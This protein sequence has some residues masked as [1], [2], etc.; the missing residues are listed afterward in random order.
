MR[1]SYIQNNDLSVFD[2]YIKYLGALELDSEII[3]TEDA[4]D[5]VL[6]NAVFAKKCDPM[7]NA[8]AMDGIAV[9]AEATLNANDNHPVTLILNKDF[10]FVNTG[11]AIEG[12]FNAVI[13]IEEVL[14]LNDTTVQIVS[15]AY[16]W[17]H[18]RVKGESIVEGE[19]LLP[20]KSVLRPVDIGAVYASANITVEVI[21]K[22][23]VGII[24]T[25]KEMVNDPDLLASGNLMESNSKMFAAMARHCNAI[26]V[27]YPIVADEEAEL[28]CALLK[29]V[30]AND[31]VLINAGSSSGTK[32]F[33]VNVIEKLGTVYVHGLAV[34]PGKPT[35][36]GK[37]NNKPVIGIPG[38]PVSAYIVFDYFVKPILY[39]MQGIK[40]NT[41]NTVKVTLT[42]TVTSSFKNTEIIR[43]SMGKVNNKLVATPLERG[44]AQIM[45]LVKADGLLKI[46]RMLEGIDEGSIVDVELQKPITQIENNLVIIGSHDLIIDVLGD[47][48]P[49][50]SAHTGS[51]GGITALLKGECHIAPIHLLDENGGQY[52]IPYIKKYFSGKNMALIKVAGR[53]QGIMTQKGNPHN[54][55]S[56][57][58]IANFHCAFANRQRGSGTRILFDYLL[59][60]NNIK[61]TE[62]C[63]YEKEYNT[64]LAVGVAVES[65]AAYAGLGIGSVAKLLSL[66]FIK[67]GQEDYDFLTYEENLADTRIQN[68]IALLNSEE[69]KL[70]LNAFGDYTTEHTGEIKIITC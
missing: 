11:N 48:L 3:K 19:M 20:S 66:D 7:Y 63:G 10:V 40:N 51:M 47:K 14:I 2:E 15:P 58:D 21:R 23:T 8:S 25:G 55:F 9:S 69:I 59:K 68:L 44:A 67:V 28:E 13:M 36:L 16:P 49:L 61:S 43:V 60:Q 1:K 65:N 54:I 18:I 29:A 37:I 4:L 26:P 24:P 35:I 56:V 62:I 70:K 46:D 27:T 41:A 6:K 42:R 50:T 38:Y 39:A 32:D 22:A 31:I 53:T 34:K 52:N 45:S 57:K 30:E 12:R 64:H 33:T 17:Q 5:R